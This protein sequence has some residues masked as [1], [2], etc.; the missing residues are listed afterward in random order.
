MSDAFFSWQNGTLKLR[1]YIQP[2]ARRD[3][4][5]GPHGDSLKVRITAPPVDG[6][7]NVHLLKF[8]AKEFGVARSQIVITAGRQSRHK[9]LRVQGPSRLPI[10][11]PP[12]PA[13]AVNYG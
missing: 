6:K 1:I 10:V 12:P 11:I 13:R 4:I 3:E 7:A 9:Q 8:L 2:R 5:V